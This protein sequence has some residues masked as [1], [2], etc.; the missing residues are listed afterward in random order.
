MP[1]DRPSDEELAAKVEHLRAREGV[2]DAATEVVDAEEVAGRT[3]WDPLA[4]VWVLL[5]SFWAAGAAVGA[6][7]LLRRTAV[8]RGY[9]R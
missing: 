6:L 1:D 3:R 9:R 8:L 4:M 7:Y 5:A 2:P